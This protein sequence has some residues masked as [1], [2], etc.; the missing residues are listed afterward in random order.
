MSA[1]G[2]EAARTIGARRPLVRLTEL[3]VFRALLGSSLVS[4]LLTAG[5]VGIQLT[6]SG[7]TRT[8]LLIFLINLCVVVGMQMFTGNSG[9]VSFGHVAFMGIGAYTAAL[10]STNPAVKE[11]QIADAPGFILNA[12]LPFVAATLVAVGVAC[13]VAVPIGFVFARLS[14][15]AAAIATLSWLVIVRTVIA[16][17]DTVTNGTF[18]LYGIKEYTNVWWGLGFAVVA[19]TIARLFRESGLGLGLRA[20]ATDELVARAVGVSML[21]ARLSA[22][23]ASAGIAALGGVLYAHFILAL[24]PYSFF[25]DLTFVLLVMMVVGGRSVS[26]AVGGAALISV[27]SEF[28]RRGE[29]ATQKF[30]L[31]AMVLAAIF[32]VMMMVR[33]E[34][35]FGRWELDELLVRGMR[36]VRS[37]RGRRPAGSAPL[38]VPQPG[39]ERQRLRQGDRPDRRR[40]KGGQARTKD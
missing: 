13:V 14:G 29:D 25:F 32:M 31:S 10:M 19:I 7:P 36:K 12:E 28:L 3:W 5:V 35:L 40:E 8:V 2:G 39:A 9:V 22:W 38:A 34:G 27:L 15:A 17:W 16:N 1:A 21:R 6:G 33:P 18:T 37:G 20:T 11:T 24:A 23:V 26:G 30:G 4:A